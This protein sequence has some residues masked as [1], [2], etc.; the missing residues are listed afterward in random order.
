MRKLSL[1]ILALAT[2]VGPLVAQTSPRPTR[3]TPAE[4]EAML[5]KAIAHY[6]QVGRTQALAD[7]TA[8]KA[9]FADR[10]LYVFC[11]GP[12]R[13]VTAHGADPKQI[14]TKVD[15]LKDVDGKAFGAEV[16]A[17]GNKPGGGSVEYR[18]MNP[19]SRQVEPKVSVVRKVGTEIC[20]VGAYK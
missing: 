6:Q 17:A 10:D 5:A 8:K 13:T 19:V 4:A 7:F 11:V 18:W 3:G 14:G 9:P 15:D 1:V 12:D 20:G 2:L 16:L